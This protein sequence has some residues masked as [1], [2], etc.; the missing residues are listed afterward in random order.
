MH[1]QIDKQTCRHT[2][3]ETGEKIQKEHYKKQKNIRE[4]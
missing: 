1:T 4:P 3:T 2:N